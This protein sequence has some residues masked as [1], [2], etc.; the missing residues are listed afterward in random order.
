[1]YHYKLESWGGV[2]TTSKYTDE[3]LGI[4]PRDELFGTQ[5]TAESLITAGYRGLNRSAEKNALIDAMKNDAV[6]KE[7]FAGYYNQG[8]SVGIQPVKNPTQKFDIQV[9]QMMETTG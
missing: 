3:L 1:M 4:K 9:K 2:Q 7:K 6:F 8:G 5:P